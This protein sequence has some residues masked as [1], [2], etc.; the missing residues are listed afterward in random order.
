MVWRVMPRIASLK[1]S[2]ARG[3]HALSYSHC[4]SS[5]RLSHGRFG[6]ILAD[7]VEFFLE[8]FSA[9]GQR[10]KES[11]ECLGRP[12]LAGG[13]FLFSRTEQHQFRVSDFSG[14]PL[15]NNTK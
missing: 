7:R 5:A 11:C 3:M 12:P 10:A 13:P 8:R 4:P 2:R 15:N 6:Q 1:L 14:L 9:K